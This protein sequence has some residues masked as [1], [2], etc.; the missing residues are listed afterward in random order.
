MIY[1][2]V[3]K[4]FL[5]II[6]SSIAIII[7][8]PILIPVMILLLSTGENYIFYFQEKIGYKNTKF[9]IIKFATMLKDSP[10]IG[11]G[12]HTI[13]NDPRILPFGGFLRKTK[14]NELPQL[15]NILLGSMSIIGPRPLV[16]KTFDP[17]PSHVKKKI[18]DVKP[19]LSGVGSIIFRNEEIIMNKSKISLDEFYKNN[20]SPYKGE[21]ELW[22]Q[23]NLSFYTDFMIIFVTIWVIFNPK[24]NL[25]FKLFKDLPEKPNYLDN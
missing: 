11:S 21:L 20:I 25:I 10:N 12:L 18:Y 2:K 9:K 1:K 24:S 23:R 17:Y 5:D 19:G 16:D 14:I 7:L 13:K 22:Y 6:L 8:L 4:R 15:F 3:F